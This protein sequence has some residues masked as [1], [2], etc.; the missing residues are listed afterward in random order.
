MEEGPRQALFSGD[1]VIDRRYWGD[2]ALGQAWGRFVL[3]SIDARG[4]APCDWF[5]ISQGF[6]TYRYL[7]LFFREFYPRHDRPTPP[8]VSERIA[9]F[10]GHLFPE[11]F[12]AERGIIRP[13]PRDYWLRSDLGAA[14]DR[15]AGDPHVAFF[16]E[17][18]PGHVRGEELCC[19]APLSRANFSRAA[20]RV[21]ERPA[22]V[23]VS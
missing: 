17:R 1:T 22:P 19:L 14:G 12:D 21:I 10:A 15:P 5:L 20:W 3:E 6:R 11:R 4:E 16:L 2:P 13:D 18:N 9:A 7:S 8:E 23:D